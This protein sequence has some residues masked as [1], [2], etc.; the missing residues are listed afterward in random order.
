M[1][2]RLP[3]DADY[4]CRAAVER[5]VR[6]WREARAEAAANATAYPVDTGYGGIVEVPV[7]PVLIIGE[8]GVE[9]REA[10]WP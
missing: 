6:E 10:A 4:E 7:E 3:T 2:R 9:L 5:R 1:V 8:G